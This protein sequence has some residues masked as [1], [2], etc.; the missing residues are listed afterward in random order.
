MAEIW[1]EKFSLRKAIL[2]PKMNLV[3]MNGVHYEHR[4]PIHLLRKGI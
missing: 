3:Q 4:P 2:V 1:Q